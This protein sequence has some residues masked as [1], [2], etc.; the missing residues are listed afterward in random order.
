MY[1]NSNHTF[2]TRPP[3]VVVTPLYPYHCVFRRK[4]DT[5]SD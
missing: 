3:Q 1:G 2:R 4:S 5:H